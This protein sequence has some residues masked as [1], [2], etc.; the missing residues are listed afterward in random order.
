MFARKFFF[1]VFSL[2]SFKHDFSS[3]SLCSSIII[4]LMFHFCSIFSLLSSYPS[5]MLH[6]LFAA[7]VCTHTITITLH[8][9]FLFF[10]F[11]FSFNTV[12]ASLVNII[13]DSDYIVVYRFSSD[14]KEYTTSFS[15]SLVLPN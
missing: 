7:V 14:S 2:F 5:S 15:L 13:A 8:Y 6:S 9:I 10:S 4:I 11:F 12:V 1:G 3:L